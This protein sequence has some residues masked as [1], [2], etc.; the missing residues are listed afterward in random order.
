MRL[1]QMRKVCAAAN[2]PLP[3]LEIDFDERVAKWKAKY[4]VPIETDETRF[5]DDACHSDDLL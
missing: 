2:L 5:E 4:D 1:E 3:I